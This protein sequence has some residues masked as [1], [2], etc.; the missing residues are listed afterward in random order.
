MHNVTLLYLK[1]AM[2]AFRSGCMLSATVMLGVAVEHT[3]KLLTDVIES[4]PAK[5]RLFGPVFTERSFLKQFNKFKDIVKQ[6]IQEFPGDIKE[7]FDTHFAGILSIIRTSRNEAGHPTGKIM[8]REQTFVLLH[9][10]IPYS[11]K[12]YQLKQYFESIV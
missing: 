11:K 10:M 4:N 1:E 3:F 2:Q 8:D 5:K 12:M 7:D 9:L 6:N